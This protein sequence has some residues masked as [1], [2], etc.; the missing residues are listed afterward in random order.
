MYVYSIHRMSEQRVV[1]ICPAF[2]RFR[3]ATNSHSL[4]IHF[5]SIMIALDL[6]NEAVFAA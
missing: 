5:V 4:L 2:L 3:G 6:L 1:K